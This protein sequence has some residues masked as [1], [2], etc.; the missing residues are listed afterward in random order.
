MK[1]TLLLF[2]LGILLIFSIQ[3]LFFQMPLHLKIKRGDLE[4]Y[5]DEPKRIPIPVLQSIHIEGGNVEIRFDSTGAAE[6]NPF[7]KLELRG[8]RLFITYM[9]DSTEEPGDDFDRH[10]I[11]LLRVNRVDSVLA[12]QSKTSIIMEPTQ[13]P[14]RLFVRHIGEEGKLS[15]GVNK[16]CSDI[17][18]EYGEIQ[19]SSDS[20]QKR[21]RIRV[22]LDIEETGGS[23]DLR[24]LEFYSAHLKLRR[25]FLSL[26][27]VSEF[28]QSAT[29]DR[30]RHTEVYLPYSKL[31]R[32]KVTTAKD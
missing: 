6:E 8:D 30:D 18:D 19:W 25:S 28:L 15:F 24:D 14:D 29:V 26:T 23:I 13:H 16:D 10:P 1:K 5:K 31:D 12:N 17:L 32:I 27:S 20:C 21:N 11:F 2:G 3:P 22:H 7:Y 4:T 9:P